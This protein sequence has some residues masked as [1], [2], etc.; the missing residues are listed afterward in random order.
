[1]NS[2]ETRITKYFDERPEMVEERIE[3]VRRKIAAVIE[4]NQAEILKDFQG[5]FIEVFQKGAKMQ[6]AGK[7]TAIA[8]VCISILRS[9]LLTKTYQLRI[10]LYGSDG[11]F[12]R[13]ECEGHWNVGFVFEWLE[14]DINYFTKCARKKL[15][16]IQDAEMIL[17]MQDYQEQYFDLL[18]D[19]CAEHI[20]KILELPSWKKLKR[21]AQVQISYGEFLDQG[22]LLQIENNE[23][24]EGEE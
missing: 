10:D 5:A 22:T 4:K 19:F 3:E 11:Y 13:A 2:M 16:R 12:D 1:M 14:E 23:V 8:Y 24:N 20:A 6:E 9:S 15:V 21:E 18:E 17:F 7:K